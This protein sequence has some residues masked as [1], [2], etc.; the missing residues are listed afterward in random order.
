MNILHTETLK[1]WGGEQNKVLKELI[2]AKKLGHKVYFICNPFAEIAKRGK[3]MELDVFEFEMNKKNFHKTIP[4]FL[5]F[6]KDKNIDIL[7]SHGS[8]DSWIVAIAGNLSSKKPFLIRERHNLF[9]IKG[10]LSKLLH[11]KLFDKIITVSESVKNYLKDIKV[12]EEK[13]FMLP[14]VVD[15]KHFINTKPT[16]RKEFAIP[17]NAIVVGIFTSL[18]KQKGV[19]DFFEVAK[20]ILKKYDNV[21]TVFGG[22][23]SEKV[24][25]E[26]DDFFEKENYD[27]KRVIWTG[28]KE[29]A[30]SVMKDFDIFLFPTHIEGL[31]T[32]IIEAMTSKLPV[33]V[34]DKGPMNILVK[35]GLNGFT[36][37]FLDTKKLT[38][39]ASLLIENKD[40]R[41][42]MGKKSFEIAYVNFV[43]DVL[44]NRMKKLLGKI[45][46]E[47]S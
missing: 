46:A 45:S 23:Y 8:T 11:R 3:K 20:K 25:R 13:N 5:K 38:E 18:Y 43:E 6:I 14:D 34:Y 39:A 7:F 42:K 4:F 1:G 26:I 47:I 12:K 36:V 17:D 33:I 24:K 35:N 15:T 28:F 22:N 19:Y 2:A 30:A 41:K 40:L 9:V 37:P 44:I 27:K 29:D 31:G 21:Y 16:L 10:Y 32:V